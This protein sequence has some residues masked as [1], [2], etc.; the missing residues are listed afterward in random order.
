MAGHRPVAELT[1]LA[2]GAEH[3]FALTSRVRDW[4]YRLVPVAAVSTSG[5][6]LATRLLLDKDYWRDDRGVL[7]ERFARR[8]VG[9]LCGGAAWAAH[10]AY[11][12]LGLPTWT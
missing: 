3:D 8:T 5:D 7:L 10:L 12:A 6:P 9:A 4:V 11:A 2:A 1:E